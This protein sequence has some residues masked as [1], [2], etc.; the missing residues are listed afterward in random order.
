KCAFNFQKKYCT[1]IWNQFKRDR[2]VDHGIRDLAW[3]LEVVGP[4]RSCMKYMPIG[5]TPELHPKLFGIVP[6]E[7]HQV[8]SIVQDAILNIKNPAYESGHMYEPPSHGID[9]W[10]KA[11]PARN[12]NYSV[13]NVDHVPTCDGEGMEGEL[14][15]PLDEL[16]QIEGIHDV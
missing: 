5:A 2:I 16:E 12:L 7:T 9:I 13:A 11:I 8:Y 14:P 1:T 4:V 10:G 3:R 15:T 6:V